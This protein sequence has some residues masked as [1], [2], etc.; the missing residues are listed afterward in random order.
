[1]RTRLVLASCVL[2]SAVPTVW[3]AGGGPVSMPSMSSPREQ[4]PEDQAK[5]VYNDGVR[6]VHKADRFDA[7]ATQLTDAKRR[8]GFRMRNRRTST[9]L[10]STAV[11]RTGC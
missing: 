9:R 8:I 3:A 7:S 6:D 11:S 2:V 1:M 5:S 4:S 10:P